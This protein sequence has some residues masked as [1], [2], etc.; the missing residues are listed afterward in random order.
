VSLC[1]RRARSAGLSRWVNLLLIVPY[2]NL[3]YIL[4]L[5][6]WPSAT[7]QQLQDDETDEAAVR[8]SSFEEID[9]PS[10]AHP[11]NSNRS[12]LKALGAIAVTVAVVF[13]GRFF[14]GALIDEFRSG[15]ADRTN[16]SYANETPRL[17]AA[18]DFGFEVEFPR[19]PTREVSEVDV[20]GYSVPYA[21]YKLETN[22]GNTLHVVAV[23]DYSALPP[24]EYISDHEDA[25]MRL[26]Q[27]VGGSQLLISQFAPPAF[28]DEHVATE[29]RFMF[30][31]EGKDLDSYVRLADRGAL[32]Y[33]VW[34]IGANR[35]DF[36]NFADSLRFID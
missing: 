35:T 15:P 27:E 13:V 26:V 29:G 22:N 3:L 21:V 18:S 9:P 30:P 7:P 34:T 31:Y 24:E 10:P 33:A 28:L 2:V 25:M 19:L 20:D 11:S 12:K 4:A 16:S 1:V 14:G 36:E 17:Y 8:E 32:L 5:I 6:F 23:W